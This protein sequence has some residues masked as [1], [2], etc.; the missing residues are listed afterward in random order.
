MHTLHAHDVQLKRCCTT[1]TNTWLAPQRGAYI[2]CPG[3]A[4]RKMLH[5]RK[6]TW[7]APQRGAYIACPGCA[8]EKMLH[9]RK[10]LMA[11][12]PKR[13][14]H[15]MPMMC[16]QKDAAQQKKSHGRLPKEVHT[17][18]AHDVQS[19]RCCTT[20]KNSWPAPQRGAYIACP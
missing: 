5:N 1:E 6:N 18:H 17:L 2:A 9:N 4:I 12:S 16:N 13:C 8:I 14:I 11:G 20:E 15:C 10:K 19:K 7:P 3:C